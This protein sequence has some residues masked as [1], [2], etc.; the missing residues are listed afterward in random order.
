[1]ELRPLGK[2]GTAV[3]SYALGTMT[4]G[5]E[6]DEAASHAMLDRYLEAGGNFVDTADVYTHGASE[7]I[8]GSW[9]KQS[10]KRDDIVLAS[11]CRFA[12]G[13]GPN[14]AGLSR[15]HIQRACD[16]S[17]ERLGVETIDL[18]QAHCWDPATPLEETLAAFDELVTAGK[19]RYVGIS[20]FTGWQLQRAILGARHSGLAPVVTLQ[21]QYSLLAREIEWELVPL[22]L[23]EG[24][25]ML[26]WSPL[27]GGWLTG[28]YDREQRPEG[29]TRLGEDP[30]RGVEAYDKR[31][32]DRTWN[33]VDA[34]KE[35]AETHDASMAQVA[36]AWVTQRPGVTSTILGTRTV[37]QLDDNLAAAELVLN[38][39]Q[40]ERLDEVSD[41]GR[42]DYPYGFIDEETSDRAEL[43]GT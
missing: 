40:L 25:G 31:N 35:I 34:V 27:G 2:T 16:A 18:Y 21:P 17:L 4:F 32:T 9:L 37:E 29:A 26:P 22:C 13:D 23:D 8:I 12:M 24:V 43:L 6:S 28:K 5:A 14:D 15:T 33:V 19:V 3:S 30:D 20:N 7:S 11:K 36:L 38:D 41:P 39:D 10:G 1:M 42:P